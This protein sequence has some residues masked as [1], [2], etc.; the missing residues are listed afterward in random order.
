MKYKMNGEHYDETEEHLTLKE[1]CAYC[2]NFGFT[3]RDGNKTKAKYGEYCSMD[4]L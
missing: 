4:V 2:G 3:Y 1:G